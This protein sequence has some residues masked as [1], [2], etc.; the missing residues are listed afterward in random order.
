MT[1]TPTYDHTTRS[2]S[3]TPGTTL[4]LHG[5]SISVGASVGASAGALMG[6]GHHTSEGRMADVL[7][8]FA[9]GVARVYDAPQNA[10]A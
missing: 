3:I 9:E 2:L 5:R 1:M 10:P 4:R 6:P 7:L 8:S